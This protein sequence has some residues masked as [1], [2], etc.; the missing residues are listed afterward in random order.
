MTLAKINLR[1]A[2]LLGS[3]LIGASPALAETVLHR[4][5]AGEPQTLDQAH[6][7]INIEEFILKDLY[8]GLTIYDAAGKI[9]PGAAETWDLSDDGLVYTFKLRADAKWSDGSP[10]TAEDF[11][12][13]LQRVEDPKTAAGYANILFPIKN[14]EKVNKGEVPVD[15]LGLKTIDE[16]TLEITLERP[17]PLLPGTACAPD[18]PAGFQGKRRKERR[19]FRQAGRHGFQRRLQACRPYA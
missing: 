18:R 2:M 13:S 9:V 15:Q 3:I 19:R 5:N 6:T 17:D 12:F 7:S 10:V 16:K 1:T 11:V 14:A 8:E 4:G